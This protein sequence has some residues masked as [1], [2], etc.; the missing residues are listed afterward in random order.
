M[1][2]EEVF[3]TG[4]RGRSYLKQVHAS[5]ILQGQDLTIAAKACPELKAFLNT[6]LKLAGSAQ[7]P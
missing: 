6:L 3:R 4:G 5:K 1:L 2:L 7:I